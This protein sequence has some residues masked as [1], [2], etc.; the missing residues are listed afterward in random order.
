M[1]YYFVSK[2]EMS[3]VVAKGMIRIM[4]KDDEILKEDAKKMVVE[5]LVL[6]V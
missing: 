5:L 3:K 1:Y 6:I 2:E 4:S